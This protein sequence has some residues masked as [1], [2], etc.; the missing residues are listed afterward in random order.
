MPGA[1]PQNAEMA[2]AWPLRN[3]QTR[4]CARKPPLNIHF[5]TRRV[6]A[7]A[8][9]NVPKLAPLEQWQFAKTLKAA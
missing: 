4:F 7:G 5:R 9:L 1:A 2:S 3:A 6:I 8:A